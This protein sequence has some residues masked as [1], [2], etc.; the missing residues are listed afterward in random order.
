MFADVGH[1]SSSVDDKVGRKFPGWLSVGRLQARDD[2][3]EGS[4][5]D[6]VYLTGMD[7]VKALSPSP[8]QLFLPLLSP[9]LGYSLVGGVEGC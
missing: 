9:S 7:L 3:P 4:G 8:A 1:Q 2:G 6:F 5:N